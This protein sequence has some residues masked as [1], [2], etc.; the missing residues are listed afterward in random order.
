MTKPF[1]ADF[2]AGITTFVKDSLPA[3]TR[4]YFYCNARH[5]I[6]TASYRDKSVPPLSSQIRNRR[7]TPRV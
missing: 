3:S 2:Q 4:I 6:S 1:E 7:S 5:G